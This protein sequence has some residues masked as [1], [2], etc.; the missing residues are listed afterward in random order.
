MRSPVPRP[1]LGNYVARRRAFRLHSPGTCF[2]RVDKYGAHPR[3]E[4]PSRRVCTGD[5]GAT[6]F[7]WGALLRSVSASESYRKVYRDVITPEA[8][9]GVAGSQKWGHAALPDT[10]SGAQ[11]ELAEVGDRR[12]ARRGPAAAPGRPAHA[13]LHY[14][15]IDDIIAIGLHEYLTDVV[16]R[17]NAIGDET[18]GPISGPRTKSWHEALLHP[19]RSCRRGRRGDSRPH[20]ARRLHAQTATSFRAGAFPLL[21]R[22]VPTLIAQP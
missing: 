15:R 12:S 22:S 1:D 17:L 11:E 19:G 5:E 18:T 3:R 16:A 9:R 13:E 21:P 8:G 2:E 4:V 10:A 20:S 7:Q 14:G 6:D